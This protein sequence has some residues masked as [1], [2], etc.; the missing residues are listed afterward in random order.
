MIVLIVQH[1]MKNRV[2]AIHA[3]D[4]FKL[5]NVIYKMHDE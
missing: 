1:G 3:Y 2:I 5:L 4:E